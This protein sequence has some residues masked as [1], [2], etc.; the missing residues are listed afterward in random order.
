MSHTD[1]K[2]L[3]FK[4]AQGDVPG[5]EIRA[6]S[7]DWHDGVKYVVFEQWDDVAKIS[8]DI[9]V[10]WTEFTKYTKMHWPSGGHVVAIIDHKGKR[11]WA[12]GRSSVFYD[13]AA[14]LAAPIVARDTIAI[15]CGG[16]YV[17][18]VAGVRDW[19]SSKRDRDAT[20]KHLPDV[21]VRD[22][23]LFNKEL[24]ERVAKAAKA[25]AMLSVKAAR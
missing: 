8:V 15:V 23:N 2:V 4:T 16:N 9:V 13:N 14:Y 7:N 24:A 11:L 5:H 21:W 18:E 3:P 1:Y 22:N 6:W 20:I 17:L 25:D 12:E 10:H 19:L